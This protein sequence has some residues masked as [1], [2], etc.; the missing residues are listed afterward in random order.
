[1]RR[2]IKSS[3]RKRQ[4]VFRLICHRADIASIVCIRPHSIES[5]TIAS[6]T[7]VTHRPPTKRVNKLALKQMNNNNSYTAGQSPLFNCFSVENDANIWIKYVRYIICAWQSDVYF[8]QST[9]EAEFIPSAQ[10]ATLVIQP[11]RLLGG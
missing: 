8:E 11:V 9:G 1:M 5:S 7:E 10:H 2:T 4:T 6:T 3:S